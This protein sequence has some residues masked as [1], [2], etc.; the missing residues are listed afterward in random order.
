MMIRECGDSHLWQ[1]LETKAQFILHYRHSIDR[2]L[3][4]VDYS[5][6]QMLNPKLL[7]RIDIA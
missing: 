1:T 3:E 7:S 6:C 4:S 5:S 2:S